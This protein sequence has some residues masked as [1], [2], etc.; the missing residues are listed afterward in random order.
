M[1][2]FFVFALHKL[3]PSGWASAGVVV[4]PAFH[5]IGKGIHILLHTDHLR[6]QELAV[7]AWP[8]LDAYLAS[9]EHVSSISMAIGWIVTGFC[10]YQFATK[11]RAAG[12]KL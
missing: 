3:G 12:G 5:P 2:L 8:T 11:L 4:P 1:I 6:D 10:L 9:C 7:S